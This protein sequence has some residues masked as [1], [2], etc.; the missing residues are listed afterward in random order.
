MKK[1]AFLLI[2]S[3]LLL[4]GC[5]LD[6]GFIKLGGDTED[7]Q[8]EKEKTPENPGKSEDLTEYTATIETC[9]DAIQDVATGY[10]TQIDT[11][12][13]SG[14]QA[15]NRL[16]NC[17]KAQIT[18]N[19]CLTS[20]W[21]EKLNTADYGSDRA[22]IQMGSGK[23]SKAAYNAGTFKWN[24]TAKIYKVDV[25]AYAFVNGENVDEDAHLNV[26]GESFALFE[27]GDEP[28]T[29][30]TFSKEFSSGVTNLTLVSETGRVFLKSLKI[31][32]KL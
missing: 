24:S 3:S 22:I 8:N 19:E 25:K 15:A 20:T 4:S 27:T 5:T 9:G 23:Y 30:K 13:E 16:T 11:D 21:F 2:M 7:K 29:L 31:T 26:N 32:W 18:K 6:L 14:K 28:A 10:G 1:S 12:L 17:L